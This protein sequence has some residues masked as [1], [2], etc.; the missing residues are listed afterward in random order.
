MLVARGVF[1]EDT[2]LRKAAGARPAPILEPRQKQFIRD[3]M[4]HFLKPY[5]KA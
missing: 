4:A 1:S 2:V 3:A 5:A